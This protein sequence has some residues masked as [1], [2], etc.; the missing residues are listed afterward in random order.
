[1]SVG[2]MA[3]V[4]LTVYQQ[5]FGPISLRGRCRRASG[6]DGSHWISHVKIAAIKIRFGKDP[7][8]KLSEHKK[9]MKGEIKGWLKLHARSSCG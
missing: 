4:A 3:G 5:L 2:L 7:R 1:M 9:K 8:L 6:A